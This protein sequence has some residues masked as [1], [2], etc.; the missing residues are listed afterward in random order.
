MAP[1][2]LLAH[3]ARASDGDGDDDDGATARVAARGLARELAEATTT[4]R[5]D[6]A[7]AVRTLCEATTHARAQDELARGIVAIARSG[8]A[9]ASALRDGARE[10]RGEREDEGER[11]SA[12]ARAG[13]VVLRVRGWG[14]G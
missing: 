2:P 14:V 13:G 10:R 11:A 5:E 9:S 4:G 12:D 8:N 1:S 3:V 7:R 6:V